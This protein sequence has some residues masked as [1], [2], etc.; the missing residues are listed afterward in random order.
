MNR[1]LGR[2]PS[3]GM[4]A[5]QKALLARK[6]AGEAD[7]LEISGPAS[8]ADLIWFWNWQ[9]IGELLAWDAAGRPYVCGPNILFGLSWKP[10]A[11]RG[12][13]QILESPR[14]RLLFT[15]SDWYARLIDEHRRPMNTAPLVVWPYPI[16]PRPEGPLFHAKYD[17]LI[18]SKSGPAGL[19]EG[20]AR[21]FERSLL[22][23]Y[24]SFQRTELWEAARQSRACIYLSGDDRGPLAL[25]EILLAGCP[26]IGIERGAPW[27]EAGRT[28]IRIDRLDLASIEAAAVQILDGDWSRDRVREIALER[29][30]PQ[31]V[32]G[33]VLNALDRARAAGN[34]SQV[35]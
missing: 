14:C 8:P 15:E 21:R 1:P 28:G 27:I 30:D 32:A 33:V 3:N 25:A 16:D 20:L 29:F 22:V 7:W 5:L 34:A 18:Y 19:A 10:G 24:G 23:R 35:S 4:Y 9:D 17:L 12:E 31:R 2:G 11:G 13:R 26:A 6:A